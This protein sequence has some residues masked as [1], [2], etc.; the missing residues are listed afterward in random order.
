MRKD[1]PDH[2]DGTKKV[3]TTVTYSL[4][5]FVGHVKYQL[6]LCGSCLVLVSDVWSLSK[7][8]LLASH[9]LSNLLLVE[10]EGVQRLRT[11][12]PP[13]MDSRVPVGWIGQV[14]GFW[15]GLTWTC[16]HPDS[17]VL[18]HSSS[19][20]ERMHWGMS[21]CPAFSWAQINPL[22]AGCYFWVRSIS[23]FQF[24]RWST[25]KQPLLLFS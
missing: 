12:V 21:G 1:N 16:Q 5:L 13:Q 6:G 20:K 24:K 10:L 15:Y 11:L 17:R 4:S 9:F 19:C 25:W 7:W 3:Q 18:L 22:V 2:A 8:Y 23:S 14:L